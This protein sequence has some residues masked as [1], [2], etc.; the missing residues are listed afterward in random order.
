M[1]LAVFDSTYLAGTILESFRKSFKLAT[2]T[3]LRL[4]P[5]VRNRFDPFGW[6]VGL[7]SMTRPVTTGNPILGLVRG[8]AKRQKMLTN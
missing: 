5:Q 4:F 3:H 2:L 1:A 8:A 7:G 6:T